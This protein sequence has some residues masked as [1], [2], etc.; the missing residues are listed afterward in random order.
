MQGVYNLTKEIYKGFEIL[1]YDASWKPAKEKYWII[2]KGNVGSTDSFP[3]WRRPKLSR[4]GLVHSLLSSI[5]YAFFFFVLGNSPVVWVSYVGDGANH[6]S[7]IR[8][9]KK[10]QLNGL[11]TTLF[12]FGIVCK[13][14]IKGFNK[15]CLNFLLTPFLD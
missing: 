15:K 5:Q 11:A 9:V 13:F 3:K 8:F 4:A 10:V 2:N 1:H 7:L 14:A 6:A 12:I